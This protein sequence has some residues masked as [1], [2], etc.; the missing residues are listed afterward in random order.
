MLLAKRDKHASHK[1]ERRQEQLVIPLNC[2]GK[3]SITICSEG[4]LSSL[5]NVLEGNAYHGSPDPLQVLSRDSH[6]RL[7]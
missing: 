7:I 6:S 5:R 2:G 4:E 3:E 1:L